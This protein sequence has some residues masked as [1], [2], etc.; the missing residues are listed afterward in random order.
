INGTRLMLDLRALAQFGKFGSGVDRVSFSAPDLEARAW[1]LAQMKT[2]GLDATI[3]SVGNV[4]GVTKQS[5]RAVV[6]GSH[7]DSVPKGGWLDGAMG[8][9][10]GLEIARSRIESGRAATL[11][12]DVVS[13]QDEEGTYLPCLGSRSFCNDL[14]VADIAAAKSQGGDALEAAIARSGYNGTPW[15]RDPARHMAYLEAHIEQGPRLEAE[16]KRIGIVTG[17]VGIRRFRI[18][19]KGQADHAGTTPTAMRKDAAR[20]LYE[21]A[22]RIHAEFATMGSSDTVWNIGVMNVRPGAA[23]VVPSE[24]DMVV[25]FRDTS[26]PLLDAIEATLL[27]WVGSLNG[28]SGVAVAAIPIA[29]I[30]P[31]IMAPSLEDLIEATARECAAPAMRMPSGAGHDAM[32]VG[33]FMPAAMVFIPSIGGRSHDIVEDTA[34]A[35]IVLGCE[36]MAGVVAKLETATLR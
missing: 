2:A 34:E 10:Y 3:D 25:E 18:S 19:T 22:H 16:H 7:T 11:G 17:I 20:P 29:R 6:I 32:V 33:R 4:R 5:S 36:V 1:L 23:N 28:R 27:E 14:S 30:A 21:L 9:L 35:D 13:F 8:V 31:T 12:V 26:A 24:A 15:R